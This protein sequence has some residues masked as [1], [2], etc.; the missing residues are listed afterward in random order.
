M[1]AIWL[2]VPSSI[3]DWQDSISAF[4]EKFSFALFFGRIRKG[5][6]VDS[7]PPKFDLGGFSKGKTIFALL[8]RE[9][10]CLLQEFED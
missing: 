1:P 4:A 6:P 9:S 2:L 7:I 5:F 3:S 10:I 8:H